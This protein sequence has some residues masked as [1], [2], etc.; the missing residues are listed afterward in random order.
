MRGEE[1]ER[2][3][4][5]GEREREERERER[6]RE[7]EVLRTPETARPRARDS[8]GDSQKLNKVWALF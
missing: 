7:R 8:A 4:E 2:E 3:R 5:R 6:E 1:R